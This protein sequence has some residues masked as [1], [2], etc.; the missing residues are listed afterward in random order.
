MPG[1]RPAARAALGVGLPNFGPHAS[2]RSIL[3]VASTAER[4]GFHSVW[5]FERLLLPVTPTGTNPYGLP[6]HNATVYDSLETLTWVA[7]STRRIAL[8]TIVMDPLFQSPLV[9]AKRMATVDRLSGGRLLAGIGQGWMSEEFAAVGLPVDRRGHRFEAHIAAMRACWG[10]DPVEYL[11]PNYRIPSSRIGPKPANG[12]VPLLIGGIV[13]PAVERAARMGDGFA[14]V[15]LDW[16]ILHTQM[17]W[18]RGAGGTGP[19]VV[20]VNPETVNAVD[21]HKPFTGQ[22]SSVIEDLAKVANEGVEVLVWDLNMAG[23]DADRQVT[24][25]ESLASALHG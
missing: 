19:V 16:E 2:P 6:E 4:L 10:P 11:G 3:A 15:F 1:S 25:L 5:T 9:L 24:I 14:A 12:R 7:A 13:Q 18:Y 20:R 21:P 23:L 22:I 17:A 8:G